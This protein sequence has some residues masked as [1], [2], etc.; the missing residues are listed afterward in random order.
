[1]LSE[2]KDDLKFRNQRQIYGIVNGWQKPVKEGI[3]EARGLLGKVK[4]ALAASKL[5]KARVAEAQHLASDAE[6]IIAAIERD[7]SSGV[8]APAYTLGKVREAKLMAEG[9]LDVLGGKEPKRIT[10]K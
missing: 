4:P 7:G 9:A 3:V 8:H 1:V 6:E 2:L 5:G 10:M